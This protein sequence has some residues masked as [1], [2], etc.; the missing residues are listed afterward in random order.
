MEKLLKQSLEKLLNLLFNPLNFLN[1]P[2][3]LHLGLTLITLHTLELYGHK[4][5]VKN[6]LDKLLEQLLR[7]PPINLSF[8]YALS[9][10]EALAIVDVWYVFEK[11]NIVLN[12]ISKKQI[13][14]FLDFLLTKN[15]LMYAWLIGEIIYLLGIDVRLD[16]FNENPRPYKEKNKIYDT[17][18]LTHLIFLHT[19]Y[20]HNKLGDL[21]ALEILELLGATDWIIATKNL[22]LAAE[23]AICLD[24]AK[25]NDSQAYKQ[26]I[27]LLLTNISSITNLNLQELDFDK[28]HTISVTM[29][30]LAG[31]AETATTLE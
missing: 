10:E 15:D 8:N 12:K 14:S 9:S 5:F 29:V 26:L 22:D 6:K 17:Y 16:F 23:V 2:K 19:D 3:I 13:A 18:W 21:L 4:T 25:K 30:A 1:T 11:H 7:N 28:L 27:S 31:F 24:I 20:L